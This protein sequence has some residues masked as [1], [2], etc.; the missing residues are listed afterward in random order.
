MDKNPPK[1][2]KIK[3]QWGKI[4]KKILEVLGTFEQDIYLCVECIDSV[5]FNLP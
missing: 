1:P 5:S 3:E 4:E 2:F